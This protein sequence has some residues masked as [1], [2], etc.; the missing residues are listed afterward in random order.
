[1][2]AHTAT[3]IVEKLHSAGLNLSL[4]PTGGLAVAPSSHLTE[5]LRALI[6]DSKALLIDWV[7]AA[8]DASPPDW[9]ALDAAYLAHHFNCPTCI[10]AG[11]GSRYGLRCGIGAALW[12]AY[13]QADQPGGKKCNPTENKD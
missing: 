4:A 10:A 9:H 8:N 7:K 6:R 1:M 3:A 12:R 2:A 5:D 13:A 11:R